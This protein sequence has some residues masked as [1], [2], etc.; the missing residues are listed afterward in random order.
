VIPSGIPSAK[1][2]GSLSFAGD[3]VFLRL[4]RDGSLDLLEA[5]PVPLEAYMGAEEPVERVKDFHSPRRGKRKS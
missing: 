2:R 3:W 1:I 5:S 4:R